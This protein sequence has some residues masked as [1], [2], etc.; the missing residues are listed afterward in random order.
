MKRLSK[1]WARARAWQPDEAFIPIV[2]RLPA[3]MIYMRLADPR[4]ATPVLLAS[5]PVVVRQINAEIALEGAPGGKDWQ[6][7]STCGL[8]RRLFPRLTR[9]TAGC[10]RLRPR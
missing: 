5:L 8:I 2:N 7:R 3:E 6:R 10:F 9:L 4:P 1:R